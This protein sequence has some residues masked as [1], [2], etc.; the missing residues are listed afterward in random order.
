MAK[1][2]PKKAQHLL[3]VTIEIES[4]ND[5]VKI[6]PSVTAMLPNEDGIVDWVK[7]TLQMDPPF[8]PPDLPFRVNRVRC[9]PRVPEGPFRRITKE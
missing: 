8:L 6:L 5:P 3:Q 4:C 2:I 1:V 7:R 9:S